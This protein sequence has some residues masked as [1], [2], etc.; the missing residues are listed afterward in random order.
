MKTNYETETQEELLKKTEPYVFKNPISKYTPNEHLGIE[1]IS[2]DDDFT[3]ID[4]VYIAP[5][6]YVNGGWIQMDSGCFIRPIGSDT[7]YK[8]IQ[9][10]NIPVAPT[11]YYFKSKGQVHHFTLLFPPL[12]KSVKHIDIIER[13]AEGTYFNFF[14]VSLQ[15]NEP[16]LIRIINEN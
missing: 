5:K 3:R 7:R 6:M 11:K 2:L 12:P 4:F 8:M 13:L 14:K 15:H 16:T 10:I 9:A 1:K